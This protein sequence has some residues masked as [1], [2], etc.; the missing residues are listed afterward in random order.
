MK[1]TKKYKPLYK[2]LQNADN[3]FRTAKSALIQIE[4]ILNGGHISVRVDCWHFFSNDC[5]CSIGNRVIDLLLKKLSEKEVVGL[6][7]L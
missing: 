6:S 7:E 2:D 4:S 3:Q 5:V 1:I